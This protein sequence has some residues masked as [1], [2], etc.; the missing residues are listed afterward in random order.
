[1]AE[2]RESYRAADGDLLTL[3][4]TQGNLDVLDRIEALTSVLRET[5]RKT[6]Q[7][8]TSNSNDTPMHSVRREE[9]YE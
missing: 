9:R 7:A 5:D 6:K 3:V 2:V 8:L 1:M 4:L